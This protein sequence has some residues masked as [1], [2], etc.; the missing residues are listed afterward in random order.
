MVEW[1]GSSG[2]SL[3]TSMNSRERFALQTLSSAEV[4]ADPRLGRRRRVAEPPIEFST[5]DPTKGPMSLPQACR[6]WAEY[7]R[8]LRQ[9]GLPV[10]PSPYRHPYRHLGSK[11]NR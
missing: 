5:R 8:R 3:A 9:A 7:E 10:P 2:A 6:A 11:F 1:S 4:D